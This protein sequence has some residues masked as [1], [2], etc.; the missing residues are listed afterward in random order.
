LIDASLS[1]WISQIVM[2]LQPV[3]DALGARV[4]E[5]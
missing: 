1:T 5:E 3:W 4:E 2:T